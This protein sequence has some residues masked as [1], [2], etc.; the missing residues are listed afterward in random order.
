MLINEI[1][2]FSTKQVYYKKLIRY[3]VIIRLLF[4]CLRSAL[5]VQNRD[6]FL[7][8][9]YKNSAFSSCPILENLIQIIP[10]GV[11]QTKNHRNYYQQ[12]SLL[13]EL[14]DF[15]FQN[16]RIIMTILTSSNYTGTDNNCPIIIFD[17][18]CVLYSRNPLIA[19]Y[20]VNC[21]I[22]IF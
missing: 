9:S 21:G 19:M 14:L 10:S 18:L 3:Y 16:I 11:M 22:V 20:W 5:P 12:Y 15:V 17:G 7:R 6:Q 1:V 13:Q 4:E 2:L 8:Y